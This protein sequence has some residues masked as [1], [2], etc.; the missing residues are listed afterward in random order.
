MLIVSES[1]LLKSLDVKELKLKRHLYE[2]MYI[3]TNISI[4]PFILKEISQEKL[5]WMGP[6][7]KKIKKINVD[8]KK[9]SLEYE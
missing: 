9:V 2:L 5:M 6:L 7:T 8:V 1:A 3:H 4:Y